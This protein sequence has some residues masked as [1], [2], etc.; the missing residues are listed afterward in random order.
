MAKHNTALLIGIIAVAAIAFLF[1]QNGGGWSATPQCSIGLYYE[2]NQPI[3][4]LSVIATAGGSTTDITNVQN[5]FEKIVGSLHVDTKVTLHDVKDTDTVAVTFTAAWGQPKLGTT[6]INLQVYPLAA[7]TSRFPLTADSM[8]FTVTETVAQ[9]NAAGGKVSAD[10][11]TNHWARA[12]VFAYDLV[13]NAPI[14]GASAQ[15][16]MPVSITISLAINGANKGYTAANL[17]GTATITSSALPGGSIS[18]TTATI[19]TT[20]ASLD[21][22]GNG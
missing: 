17:V 5:G 10:G 1:L 15:F 4:P 9:L 8:T 7:P 20:Y 21:A 3:T 12:S 2:G 6:N 13:H 18:V 14:A 11:M 16:T 19:T 22:W